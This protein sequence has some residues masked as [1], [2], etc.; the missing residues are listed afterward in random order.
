MKKQGEVIYPGSQ[1]IGGIEAQ[2]HKLWS[3]GYGVWI[4]VWSARPHIPLF[5][6]HPHDAKVSTQSDLQVLQQTNHDQQTGNI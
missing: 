1:H 3:P 5:H 4:M 6:S 2:T